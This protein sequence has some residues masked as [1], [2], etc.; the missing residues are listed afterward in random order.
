[1]T[2]IDNDK[3]RAVEALVTAALDSADLAI[4]ED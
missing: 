4:V 2:E 1:M 3:A